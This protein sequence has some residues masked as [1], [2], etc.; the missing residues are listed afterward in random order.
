MT[1]STRGKTAGEADSA[2]RLVIAR[3]YLTAARD[4]AA[5]LSDGAVANPAVSNVVLAAIAFADAL[6]AKRG[7]RINH[8]DHA[9]APALLRAALGKAF[10]R[11]QELRLARLIGVK[12]AAQYGARSL[13]KADAE[14]MLAD[15]EKFADWAEKSLLQSG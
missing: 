14:R 7:G 12:S 10:P 13:R 2:G 3:A 4:G 6:T 9:A 8:K 11:E 5:A 15:L 1:R